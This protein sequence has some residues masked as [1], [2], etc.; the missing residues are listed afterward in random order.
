MGGCAD[1]T[2]GRHGELTPKKV[3]GDQQVEAGLTVGRSPRWVD[4]GSTA[5][6][7]EDLVTLLLLCFAS[8]ALYCHCDATVLLFHCIIV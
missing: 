1:H 5:G 7:L 2:W 4:L 3:P 8:S 6:S